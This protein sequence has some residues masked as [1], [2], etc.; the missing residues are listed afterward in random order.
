V[1]TARQINSERGLVVHFCFAL[2]EEFRGSRVSRSLLV[3]PSLRF[4]DGTLRSPDL[5]ICSTKAIIGAVEFKYLP[6]G[7]PSVRKDMD[8]L[9]RVCRARGLITVENKRYRGAGSPNRYAVAPDAVLCWAG[10]YYRMTKIELSPST[11][12]HL[13]QSFLRLDARTRAGAAP[14]VSPT[15][16][17]KPHDA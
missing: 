2:L 16:R 13:G 4:E 11:V 14:L 6:N 5:L 17:S 1:Y 9:L 15:R 10:V 8:T 3:E 7:V 12:E